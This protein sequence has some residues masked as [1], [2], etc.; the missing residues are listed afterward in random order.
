[1]SRKC[2]FVFSVQ[3]FV[4]FVVYSRFSEKTTTTEDTKVFT[5]IT[6]ALE[7]FLLCVLSEILSELCGLIPV[8]GI[9]DRQLEL[10]TVLGPASFR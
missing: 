5:E 7:L 4:P 9:R 10:R 3:N 8:R 6:E 1:M 2:T